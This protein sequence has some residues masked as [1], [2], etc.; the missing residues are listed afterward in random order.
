MAKVIDAFTYNGERDLLDLRLNI[1]DEYV[2]EFVIVEA[3][4]TFSRKQ[5]PLY[6]E[7]DRDQ[8]KKWGYKI[9]YFV[10]NDWGDERIWE[11]ARN[12]PNT[13]GA[14]HWRQEFYIKEH[15]QKAL[16]HLQDDDV[17]LIGDCDE[18]WNPKILDTWFAVTKLKLKVYSYW[19]NNRSSEEFWGTI[20]STWGELKKYCLNEIRQNPH[21]KTGTDMG[22]HFTSMGGYE[23]IKQKLSD[24]YTEES[25]WNPQ[26]QAHLE[27]NMANNKDFLGRDFTYTL[28]EEDWPQWLKDNRD[29]YKHLIK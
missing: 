29:K 28:S 20:I 15:L 1:L 9:K 18:V 24:S 19:L 7:R 16:N 8:F 12:S 5:K 4:Q 13:I 2:D 27:E 6:F 26:V 17:V 3:S 11:M 25:Y 21:F 23:A 14:S 10:V 22:W